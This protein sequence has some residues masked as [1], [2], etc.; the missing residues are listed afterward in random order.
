MKNWI[1]KILLRNKQKKLLFELETDLQFLEY[2]KKN[3]IKA[4]ENDIRSKL[5][6]YQSKEN[7][8]AKDELEITNLAEILAE[9]KVVKSRYATIK[10][11]IKELNQYIEMLK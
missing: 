11:N 3:V 8:D 6:E 9:I 4:N 7:R 2:Y 5:A 10:S 1:Y